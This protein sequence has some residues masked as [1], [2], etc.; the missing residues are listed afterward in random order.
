[1]QDRVDHAG[2]SGRGVTSGRARRAGRRPVKRAWQGIV[3][4]RSLG[5]SLHVP[6]RTLIGGVARPAATRSVQAAI[7]VLGRERMSVLTVRLLRLPVAAFGFAVRG[8]L[9]LRPEPEVCGIAAQPVIAGVAHADPRGDGA[10]REQPSDAM[11]GGRNPLPNR[12]YTVSVAVSI[13][14]PIPAVPGRV[15]STPETLDAR[16]LIS[17][18]G[19]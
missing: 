15:N 8:V 1:V 4:E 17:H 9:G 10:E 6:A 7:C 14:S 5:T 18:T 16:R 2:V 13:S 12:A 11:R 3:G 19:I